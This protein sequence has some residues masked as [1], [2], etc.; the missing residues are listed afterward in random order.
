[1]IINGIECVFMPM[2]LFT[3]KSFMPLPKHV[4]KNRSVLHWY[5]GGK[6]VSYNQIKKAIKIGSFKK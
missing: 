4:P 2:E 5:V 3:N 1:M 6:Y